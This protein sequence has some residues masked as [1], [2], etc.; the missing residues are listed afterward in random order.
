M[1]RP[2]RVTLVEVGP[3][4]GLQNEA[5]PVSLDI[6]L[7]LVERLAAAGLPVVEAG[8]FVSP[9]RVPQMAGSAELYRRLTRRPGTA[10]PALVPNLQGLAAALDAGVTEAAL[11]VSASEGF[12]Q[13]NIACSI[14]DSLARIAPVASEVIAQGVRLRGY[15]SCVLG[16][17]YDGAVAPE[18]VADISARL[19]D[20]GCDEISLGDTI[21]IGTADAVRALLDVV[22]ARIPA[23]RIAMHFHD[24]YGQGVANV[25]VSL[26]AGIAT[27]D[28][29]VAGLGGCPFAVGAT[30]NVATEDVLYL[31]NGLGIETGIDLRSVAETG[32]WISAQLGRDSASRAGRALLA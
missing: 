16:C 20:L 13:R 25:L 3:R 26:E 12:S 9:R 30:G 17:P 2:A 29:S 10:Y 23:E 19:L 14:A 31:L 15:V 22:A 32:A 5:V 8:S 4:D 28:C 6:K 7:A 21:G 11:F 1:A 24:T 27:F 18:A